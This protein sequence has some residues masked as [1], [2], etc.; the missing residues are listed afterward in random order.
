MEELYECECVLGRQVGCGEKEN[1][2]DV[3]LPVDPLPSAQLLS[4]V[5]L[6]LGA[7]WSLSRRS[8]AAQFVCYG[9]YPGMLYKQVFFAVL[10]CPLLVIGALLLT[11][12]FRTWKYALRRRHFVHPM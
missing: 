10:M 7:P 5:H 8:G 12:L 2:S 3:S 1:V 6:G 9:V 11:K 4:L